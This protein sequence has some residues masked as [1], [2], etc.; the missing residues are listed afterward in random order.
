LREAEW[1]DFEGEIVKEGRRVGLKE[2]VAVKR[3]ASKKISA[4][5]R[6]WER[7]SE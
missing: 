2:A 6:V 1:A 5:T 4:L 3:E 7:A